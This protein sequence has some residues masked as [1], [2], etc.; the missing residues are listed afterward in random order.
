VNRHGA[1][2]AEF[3]VS[4]KGGTRPPGGPPVFGDRN[5]EPPAVGGAGTDT[6]R[7]RRPSTPFAELWL[8]RGAGYRA[9]LVGTFGP[10]LLTELLLEY[11]GSQQTALPSLACA[12]SEAWRV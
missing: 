3:D 9:A 1:V 8:V 6:R 2:G 12:H 11:R 4:G 10:V 7:T 5:L